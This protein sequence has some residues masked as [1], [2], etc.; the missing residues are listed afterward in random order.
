[1]VSV[2]AISDTH[3]KHGH[4]ESLPDADILVHGG[5]FT[6]V[7]TLRD[8]RSY[9]EWVGRLVERERKFKFAILIAGNHDIT[10]EEDYYT[11]VGCKRFHHGKVHDHR[12][13]VKVVRNGH[14]VYLEDERVELLGVSFY[15]SPY[16]P[17]FC[18]WAFNLQRGD[19]L[20]REWAKI[21]DQGIDVLITH[22][23]PKVFAFTHSFSFSH[24]LSLTLF[25]SIISRCCLVDSI[26]ATE[27]TK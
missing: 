2:L 6:N 7:G 27:C 11:K 25:L 26:T 1:M 18:Q 5:D 13:C 22:G 14:S 12:E 21:P 15:G 17:E 24:F 10:L 19:A 16:Q 4:I 8:I 23:P 20:K 9:D 3:S